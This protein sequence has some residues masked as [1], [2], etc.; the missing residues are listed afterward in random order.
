MTQMAHKTQSKASS[1]KHLYFIVVRLPT[2]CPIV[3]F[4]MGL[5]WVNSSLGASSRVG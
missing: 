5:L 2:D 3:R 1:S 4:I